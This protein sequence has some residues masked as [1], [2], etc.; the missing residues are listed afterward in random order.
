MGQVVAMSSG[1]IEHFHQGLQGRV[2]ALARGG[3]EET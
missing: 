1:S 2:G 3:A